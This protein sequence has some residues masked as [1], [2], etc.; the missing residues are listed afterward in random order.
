MLN[1]NDRVSQ[2]P[3]TKAPSAIINGQL[4]ARIVTTARQSIQ[5][6]SIS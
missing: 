5:K 1:S 2:T 6:K 3:N 4:T